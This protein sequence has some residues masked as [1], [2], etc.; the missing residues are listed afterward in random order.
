LISV[1]AG[2]GQSPKLIADLPEREDCNEHRI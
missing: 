1:K 2:F